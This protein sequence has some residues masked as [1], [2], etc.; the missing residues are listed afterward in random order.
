M[1]L[2]PLTVQ[3]GPM[4]QACS[5]MFFDTSV[6]AMVDSEICVFPRLVCPSSNIS[7]SNSSASLFEYTCD[8]EHVIFSTGY[9]YFI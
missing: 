8:T 3:R 4:V 6:S 2:G 1:K 9:E 5:L 7:N